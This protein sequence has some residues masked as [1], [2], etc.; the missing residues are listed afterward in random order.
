MSQAIVTRVD[1]RAKVS[2]LGKLNHFV[3]AAGSQCAKHLLTTVGSEH[4]QPHLLPCP[5]SAR[6]CSSPER[7]DRR[8]MVSGHIQ[9]QCAGAPRTDA[10][11]VL[12]T[13]NLGPLFFPSKTPP[14]PRP[15]QPFPP[16]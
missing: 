2:E 13:I 10:M 1:Q 4:Q 7:R 8:P 9:R 6:A 3:F 11:A 12:I 16:P 5:P 14:P 15:P